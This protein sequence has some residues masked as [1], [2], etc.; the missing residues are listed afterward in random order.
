RMVHGRPAVAARR[1]VSC[2]NSV[3]RELQRIT[4]D[5]DVRWLQ[6]PVNQ[7]LAVQECQSIHGWQ[8]QLPGFGLGQSTTH[9]KIPE[10]LVGILHYRVQVMILRELASTGV[11]E[12]QQVWVGETGGGVP[13]RKQPLG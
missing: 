10:I 3:A 7:A 13:L 1:C 2:T 12:P 5:Q 6:M 8:E 4:D 11:H 9:E